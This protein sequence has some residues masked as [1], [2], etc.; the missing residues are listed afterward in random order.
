MLWKLILPE[1]SKQLAKAL[2][3]WHVVMVFLSNELEVFWQACGGR[4]EWSCFHL[5]FWRMRV[6]QILRSSKARR[7]NSTI[8]PN[9]LHHSIW[10]AFS[11]GGEGG[12]RKGKNTGEKNQTKKPH[13]NTGPSLHPQMNEIKKKRI[14]TSLFE[15]YFIFMV[16]ICFLFFFCFSVK[17]A[18]LIILTV[19]MTLSKMVIF[20]NFQSSILLHFCRRGWKKPII[21]SYLVYRYCTY[22][23]RS[24]W[25]KLNSSTLISED[26]SYLG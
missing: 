2:E 8:Q 26:F 10:Q 6:T 5:G 17:W 24:G 3:S 22:I 23:W 25:N 9:H 19:R 21:F 12:G 16:V 4:M 1:P 13:Q 11:G 14:K 18:S 20:N 15:I 7:I